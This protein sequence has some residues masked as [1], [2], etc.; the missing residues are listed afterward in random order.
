MI[1]LKVSEKE[2]YKN[3]G[4]WFKDYLNEIVPAQIPDNDDYTSMLTCYKVINGD[5]SDFKSML[6]TFC[7]PLGEDIGEVDEE[8]QP[9]PELH[10]SVNILKGEMIQRRDELHIML[11]SANA[12]QAKNKERIELIKRSVDEKV[13]LEIQKLQMQMQGMD[14]KQTNEF[15]QN[16]RTQLEPENLAQQ[17]WLSELEIFYNKALQYCNYEQNVLDKKADTMVDATISDRFFIYNGWRHGR[18]VITIRNPLYGTWLKSPNEKFIHKG[19]WFAYQQPI[20]LGSAIEEYN[21]S[22]DDIEKLQVTFGRGLDKRHSLGPDGKVVFDHT[23][24]DLLINQTKPSIDKTIGLSQTDSYLS[25]NR[26]LI[27]ETHFEFKA[28][29][30]LIFLSYKDEYGEL[31]TSVLDSGF[32]IP[33]KAVKEKFINRYDMESERYTW[34]DY[35]LFFTAEKLWIPRKY[36]IIRLGSDVYPI[37]REVPYQVTN[38]ERPFDSFSLSTKGAVINNRNAKSVSLVQRAIPPYLQ[39]IFIKHIMNRELAKYQ[40]AIQSID[41]DQIPDNLGEDLYGNNIRSK[42]LTYLAFIKKTNK[43]IYSG[44]QTSYGALPP[45][46]RSPGSNGYLIGTAV[47]LM[48]LHQ[49]SELV[50]Q[51]IAMAMGISPQRQATFQQGSNVSDNQQSIKQSYAITEPYFFIQSLVWKD[52]LNDWLCDFRTYCETQMKLRDVPELS[53]QYWLPGN[54][55]E[56]LTVTP[57]ML[58]PIDLGLFLQTASGAE[59]YA[60]YMLQQ[61]QAFAQNQGQGITAVS[62]ILK[63]IV[64]KGSPEEIHKRIQIEENKFHQRQVEL[65][66][67][68]ANNQQQLQETQNQFLLQQHEREKELIILKEQERRETEIQKATISALGFSKDTDVDDD[69]TPDVIEIANYTLKEEKLSLDKKTQEDNVRLKEKELKIK[70]KIANKPTSK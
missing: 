55:E 48:N 5:L 56:T 41:I 60:R 65:Q 10:N 26:T 45:S 57:K 31:V 25:N 2:K 1:K 54:V 49:L 51:E 43:D 6:K 33:E 35:G 68:Q 20:T 42:L 8:V 9:Y 21:L 19:D 70:E 58:E 50:K 64:A 18:P 44:S 12:I 13:A 28:F 38:I 62:Q 46:T 53:F 7:Q 14:E 66:Q 36:E 52:A 22:D 15:I 67:L 61:A 63:D 30:E 3:D 27:W 39:Y 32:E 47:E 17:N 34:E 40:G 69:G 11:L 24:Q 4:Q 37:Y 23:K 29:K 16:L 59:E